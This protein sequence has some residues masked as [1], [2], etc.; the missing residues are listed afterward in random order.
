MKS[1]L[2]TN[3]TI[4][5]ENTRKI[6]DIYIKNG[7]IDQISKNLS[8]IEADTIIDASNKYIIPGMIDDQVHFREPG[9]TDKADIRSESLAGVI[10]G[11]TT[12]MDMPNNKPPIITNEGLDKKFQVAKNRSFANYSFYLGATNDNIEEIKNTSKRAC[13]VKVFMGASTGN[14]LVDNLQSLENIFLHCPKLIATHCESSPI[15]DKNF[16]AAK[17]KYGDNIPLEMHTEIRSRECCI[18]SST[19]AVNLAK[20]FGS[21]L[22]VLHLTTKDE[23]DFFS[24]SD[25][26]SGKSITAEVCIHHM[27]YSKKDYATKKGFIKCNPS[28]KEESDRLALIEAVKNNNIDV[29]ATD[30]APH[31]IS[32]KTAE[33]YEDIPAGLPV[34]QHSLRACLEFYH[35]GIFSLEQI[36]EKICHNP[37]ICY[38]VKDRGFVREGYWADLVLIDFLNEGQIDEMQVMHKCGWSAFS[39]VPFR[40]N[41]LMTIVSGNIA[42]KDNQIPEQPYGLELEFNN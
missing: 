10:G 23:I 27:L 4:I 7:R 3:A 11:T 5:N 41:V 18:E 21:R 13:G 28:I 2:I 32:E 26:V 8:H 15:I 34:I 35:N 14:M 29:I 20:N 40:T 9:L 12:Y 37:A 6:S 25:N 36:I 38:N 17:E 30:H 24:N 22:H 1:I 19:L 33:K 31:L 39:D 42:Y 16:K